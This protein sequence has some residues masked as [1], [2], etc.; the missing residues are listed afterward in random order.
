MKKIYFNGEYAN[1]FLYRFGCNVMY[2]SNE[3]Y[4]NLFLELD[5]EKLKDYMNN[6][7]RYLKF[8]YI[9]DNL[10]NNIIKCIE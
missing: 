8:K 1:D 5:K 10:G 7:E 9:S 4:N 2:I 6:N 3:E